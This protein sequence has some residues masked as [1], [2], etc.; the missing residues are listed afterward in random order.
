MTYDLVIGDY[1]YSSW[2]LRGWLLFEKFS[3]ARK[4]VLLDFKSDASVAAQM[5]DFAPART[6]PTIRTPDGAVISESYAI[7]EDLADRHPEAG[8][9][10]SDP[11]AR[12]IARSLSAEMHSGF[13]ALRTACPMNLREAF[14]WQNPSAEVLADIARIEDIWSWARHAC[15]SEDSPWLCGDYSAVDAMYAPVAMRIAG[16]N[17]PVSTAASNYVDAHLNDLALRRWRAMGLVHGAHLARYDQLHQTRDWPGPKPLAAKAVDGT[18]VNPHCPYSGKLSTHML[19]L[20]GVTY[21]FCNAFCRNKS[22]ADPEAWPAF[23]ELR[24][25]LAG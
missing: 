3:I 1:A 17:L 7:A 9:W 25:S 18:P 6:V 20:D 4:Q 16:Y 19:E 8:L 21:G 22:M 12:S 10:P 15:G 23:T 2:S 11:K 5:P 14:D 13:G 24:S